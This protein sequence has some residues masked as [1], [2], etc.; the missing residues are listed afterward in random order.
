MGKILGHDIEATTIP[1]QVLI[2]RP[3]DG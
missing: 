2:E 3:M 1:D